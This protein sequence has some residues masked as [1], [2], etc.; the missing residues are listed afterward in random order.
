MMTIDN[1][2]IKKKKKHKNNDCSF[3]KKIFLTLPTE[4]F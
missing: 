3:T 1:I 4:C 2:F